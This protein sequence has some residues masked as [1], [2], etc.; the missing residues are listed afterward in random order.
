MSVFSDAL[1]DILHDPAFQVAAT[2]GA[3]TVYGN[4]ENKFIVI[5]GLETKAPTFEALDTDLTGLVHG[6]TITINAVAYTVTGIEA[7]G[8]GSTLLILSRSPTHVYTP[9]VPSPPIAYRQM[10]VGGQITML[11]DG[12]LININSVSPQIVTLPAGTSTNI[13]AHIRII[14]LGTGNIDYNKDFHSEDIMLCCN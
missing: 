10:D 8:Q 13:G 2:I 1:H 6:S 11:D 9:I 14:K 5:E 12:K 3:A 7:N 4:F